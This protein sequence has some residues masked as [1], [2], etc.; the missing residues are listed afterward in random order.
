MGSWLHRNSVF[1]ASHKSGVKIAN[2]HGMHWLMAGIFIIGDMMGGGMIALPIAMSNTGLVAG[3]IIL[4]AASIFSA[5]TGIQLSEN[6]CMMQRRW[7]EA[8]QK[9]ICRKPYP[10]MAY[11]AFGEK[12]RFLESINL[13]ITQFMIATV[14]IQ[15]CA[16][17]LTTLINVFFKT[18]IEF[19]V[20]IVVV[21]VIVWPFIMLKSPNDFWPAACLAAASSIL[22]ACL[23]VVGSSIDM[24]E[25]RKEI[26][27]P[28]VTFKN[29]FLAYGTIVFAFGGHGAFPSFQTDMRKPYHFNRSV[30][31][32]YLLITFFYFL[33]P[34]VGFEAYGNSMVDTI[35]PSIQTTW[36]SQSVNILITLHV[37][38][39]VIIVFSPLSQQVEE[40]TRVPQNFGIRRVIVRSALLGA[41]LFVAL[42]LPNFGIFLDLVGATTISLGTMILPAVFWMFI[43][44]SE[45]KR[46]HMIQ[47]GQLSKGAPDDQH[48]SI[49]D[50]WRYVDK[51]IIIWNILVLTFGISGGICSTY[52]A[53][54]EFAGANF[55]APCYVNWIKNGIHMQGASGGSVNCC[56][57]YKNISVYHL[58]PTKICSIHEN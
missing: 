33:I 56:G 31:Y 12:G 19:C 51:K 7:P 42:S 58:D 5:Y 15:L 57:G 49:M 20:F 38:P 23:M 44:A 37:M 21:V 27:Y 16:R 25:C 18:H 32:S 41:S 43:K 40:W 26:A 3:L 36:I 22:A 55:E 28:E 35:I 8:Y 4:L 52:S 2:D 14:L 24:Q 6:W 17:N 46:N 39:T 48:A 1:D 10:E 13:S 47:N 30:I 29:F 53:I 9:E 54:T 50:I 11:R 45:K 34:V